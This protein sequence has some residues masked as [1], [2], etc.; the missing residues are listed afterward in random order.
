MR[1]P[2]SMVEPSLR[3][4]NHALLDGRFGAQR[5]PRRALR[6]GAPQGT[7][8]FDERSDAEVYGATPST[9]AKETTTLP[10]AHWGGGRSRGS[11]SPSGE[12]PEA[13][14]GDAP[15]ADHLSGVV[16]GSEA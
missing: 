10:K 4:L 7:R 11:R 3:G 8:N 14:T 13:P 1:L 12:P 16:E 6:G 5:C 2:H 9:A 15:K